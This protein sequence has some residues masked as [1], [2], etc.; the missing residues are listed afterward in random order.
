MI[1]LESLKI[2]NLWADK[3]VNLTFKS[4]FV[5]LTGHNGS[6]KST[7]L[8]YLH[9]S[10]SL[11][12]DGQIGS[13]H[14]D[15][16]TELKFSGNIL[17]RSYIIGERFDIADELRRKIETAAKHNIG[18]DLFSS[19]DKIKDV[20][21]KVDKKSDKG[22]LLKKDNNTSSSTVNYLTMQYNPK[23]EVVSLP[24]TIFFKDD[25]VCYNNVSDESKKIEE[26]DIFIKEN[27]INKTLYL[28]LNEFSLQESLN[29]TKGKEEI[30]KELL[31][32]IKKV[33]FSEEHEDFVNDQIISRLDELIDKMIA[34]R[35]VK[36]GARWGNALFSSLNKFLNTTGRSVTKDDKG[37]I[38]FKLKNNKVVNWF[39][40]SR[41]EKT[42]LV[43]LLS[44]FLNKEKEVI[45]IL[46]E[47]D[48]S[49]HIEWQELLLP[50]LSKLAPQRQFILSTH[51]PALIGNIDEQYVN[52]AM[53]IE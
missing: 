27:N 1:K 5:I 47:P 17:V 11:I 10:F 24:K 19:Y 9:D 46:D 37:L 45:F 33:D 34:K 39:D 32:E 8:E 29:K 6:G 12:H 16:A 7:I 53:E 49:L 51:S 38:A 22:F 15:W 40:F 44:V 31:S 36:N 2:S 18:S 20:I 4:N 42:L 50:V 35:N 41:G 13:V 43:L 26:L 25:K 30:K 48:L 23:K 21:K 14:E 52:V 3:K 28:L